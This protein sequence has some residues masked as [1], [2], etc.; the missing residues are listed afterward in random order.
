MEYME[1]HICSTDIYPTG[2]KVFFTSY[3]VLHICLYIKPDLN[4]VTVIKQL[5]G[6]DISP[7]VVNADY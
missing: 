6:Q 2:R 5:R 3:F 7:S 1:L 4:P